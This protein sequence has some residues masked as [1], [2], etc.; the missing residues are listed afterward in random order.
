MAATTTLRVNNLVVAAAQ[1]ASIRGDLDEN[2]AEHLRLI[3][4]AATVGA[5]VIVFPELS[6]TGYELDLASALQLEKD[7]PKIEPLK[8]AA[9]EH[10]MHVL[11]S[12]PLVSGLDKPYLGAFLLSSE[13]SICYAKI[14]VHESEEKYFV[15]GKD[16]CVVSIG[17]VSTAIAI[18]ADTSHPEH[19]ANAAEHA[20]GLYVACVMK[21]EA[22]YRAHADRMGRYAARHGM[23][24][25]TANYAGSSKG[26]GAAGKS[27]FW[28]ERGELIVQAGSAGKALVVARKDLGKW[29][30]EVIT[31]F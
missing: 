8:R 20:A 24:V 31:D 17:G 10:D 7:D 23:A 22:E 16:A 2:I 29:R 6:L 1:S 28:D 4:V 27:A 26:T 25:L 19:A 30:G 3:G 12:G 5:S 14:H 15:A 9:R 21:T 18:C 13:R 11:V